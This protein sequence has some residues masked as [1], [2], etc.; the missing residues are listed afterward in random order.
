MRDIQSLPS[1][2]EALFKDAEVETAIVKH[3]APPPPPPTYEAEIRLVQSE[4][5]RIMAQQQPEVAAAVFAM[6]AGE[7]GIQAQE[8]QKEEYMVEREVSILGVK[9]GKRYVPETRTKTITRT[10]KAI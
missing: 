2:V 8:V 6:Q 9:L 7:R 1:S 10:Y 3:E 4:T 5:A